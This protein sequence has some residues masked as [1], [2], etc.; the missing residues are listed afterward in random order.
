MAS[1]TGSSR[2]GEFVTLGSVIPTHWVEQ[3][4]RIDIEISGL[5]AI[6]ITMVVTP[7][8]ETHVMKSYQLVAADAPLELVE[9]ETPEPQGTEVLVKVTAWACAIPICISGRAST[10]WADGT[11]MTLEDRNISPAFHHGA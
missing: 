2:P 3:G 7:E 1:A 9:S 10:I 5:G 11:K 6:S 8:R 4:D